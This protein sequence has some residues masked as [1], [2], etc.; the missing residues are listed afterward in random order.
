MAYH[1]RSE[2]MKQYII[3][4]AIFFIFAVGIIYVLKLLVV[5]LYEEWKLKRKK[6]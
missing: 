5:E 2:R 3:P 1:K 6:R 4:I